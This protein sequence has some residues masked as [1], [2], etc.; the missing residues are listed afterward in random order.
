[1]DE[2]EHLRRTLDHYRQQLDQK[3]EELKPIEQMIRQLEI[4][5][6]EPPSSA[7][8]ELSDTIGSSMATPSPS[9]SFATSGSYIKSP[10]ISA[11]AFYGMS[12]SEAAKKYLRL[13]KRAVPFEEL[14]SALRKGGATLGGKDPKKTLYV[15]LARNPKKEFVWPSDDHISLGEFYTKDKN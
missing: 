14:V 2:L 4:D 3:L 5:L 12:Q 9:G 1:M 6:G 10:L 7:Q 15:S 8:H 11:D 13:V